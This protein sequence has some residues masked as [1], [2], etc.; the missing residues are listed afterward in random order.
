[1][2]KQK[3]SLSIYF[4]G[5]GRMKTRSYL[6]LLIL[7]LFL[8]SGCFS[9]HETIRDIRELKQDHSFYLG[10]MTPD[11]LMLD[12][13][14]QKRIDQN[15]NTMFFSPWHQEKPAYSLAEIA[16]EFE[17]YSQNR[18]YG[19]NGRK[20]TRKWM[21]KLTGNAR[22]NHYP[23]ESLPAI[24]IRHSNLRALPTYR[25]HFNSFKRGGSG[26]PFDNL[27]V[28]AVTVNTPI[29]ISHVT[30]DRAWVMAETAYYFGWMP[31]KDVAFVD[32]DF[33]K[34]WES[35]PYAVVIKDKTP[36]YDGQGLFLFKAPLG[37]LFPK[38]RD[39]ERSME[40][41]TAAANENR[42]AV[43]K[44][45]AVS[46]ETAASKPLKMTTMNM[47]SVANEL[48]NEPY[49]WGGL[50]GNRDCSAM[51]RDLFAPFGLWLPRNSAQQAQNVGTF[52]DL[53]ALTPEEKEKAIVTQGIPYLTLLWRRGHIM[54]YIGTYQGEPLVFHNMWG[55]STRNLLGRKGKVIVGHAAITTLHPGR[56][57]FNY[58]VASADLTRNI[59]GMTLL[60]KPASLA[61]APGL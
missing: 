14:E 21:K 60:V 4:Q 17:K 5:N 20:H 58:D 41:L 2:P 38:V 50:H 53:S 31:A 39:E 43:L 15:Y 46:K 11:A 54:L 61:Y 33:M 9:S 35:H 32:A 56:E 49:G 57:L 1:M 45:V 18:G 24:T 34:S 27:Q 28:S 7:W 8:L 51:I 10:R 3:K 30:R 12:P 23:S 13:A 55:I 47:A 40:I 6:I 42:R 22:L 36:L 19:E 37:A 29:L 16:E 26:Y 59:I 48:I 25:P 44:K 52:I